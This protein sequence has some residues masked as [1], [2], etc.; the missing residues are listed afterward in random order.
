MST[1]ITKVFVAALVL[2]GISTA[3]VSNASAAPFG[4]GWYQSS[5]A[6]MAPRHD[7]T[8]TNGN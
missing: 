5:D 6:Y 3:M 4:G 7:P 1:K 8:N 2:A